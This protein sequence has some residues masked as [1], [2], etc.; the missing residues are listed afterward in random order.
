MSEVAVLAHSLH[1]NALSGHPENGPFDRLPLNRDGCYKPPVVRAPTAA[2]PRLSEGKTEF[3]GSPDMPNPSIARPRGYPSEEENAN[4][5]HRCRRLYRP[6][7]GA[8]L[9]G[10]GPLGARR[11]HQG[12]RVRS[13]AGRRVRANGS[14]AVGQLPSRDQIRGRGL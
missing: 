9:E 12:D 3:A 8:P 6:P 1:A 10:G 2:F 4:S 14:E 5:S 13:L 7:S 11:R